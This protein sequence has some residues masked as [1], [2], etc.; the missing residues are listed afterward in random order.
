M[1]VQHHVRRSGDNWSTKRNIAPEYQNSDVFRISQRWNDGLAL[2]KSRG[3]LHPRRSLLK[4][5][6]NYK[7]S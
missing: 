2:T 1:L 5:R 4:M 6:L 3:K 7:N